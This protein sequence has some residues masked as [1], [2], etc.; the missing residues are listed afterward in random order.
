MNKIK[1][2]G[3]S[4]VKDQYGDYEVIADRKDES[5]RRVVS[6]KRKKNE[7]FE[8]IELDTEDQHITVS[9]EPK[10]GDAPADSEQVIGQLTDDEMS[11]I[12]MHTEPEEDQTVDEEEVKKESLNRDRRNVHVRESVNSRK[13]A[14]KK[15]I[16]E[17][18]VDV[19]VNEF[20]ER[21]FDKL[22]ESFLKKVYGNVKSFK[23]TEVLGNNK[24]IVVEG[25]IRFASG[26]IKKTRFVF[27]SKDVSKTGKMRFAG[28][29]EQ[30]SRGKK[31]FTVTGKLNG[32]KF[33]AESMS[34]NYT[35][36]VGDKSTKIT[37][38]VNNRAKRK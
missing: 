19:K 37:G 20:D 29:N 1:K 27:E 22:G 14:T 15:P 13:R 11:D 38:T 8:K 10:F 24:N 23:T 3:F 31:S 35:A 7:A 5:L 12:E 28:M 32:S 36:K 4:V 18:Y 30:L 21:S 9:S 6:N 33:I 16:A 25:T 2:A 34:Y 26:N 17:K